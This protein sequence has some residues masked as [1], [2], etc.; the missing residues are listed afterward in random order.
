LFLLFVQAEDGIRDRNVTGV[1]TCALPICQRTIPNINRIGASRHF[2]N[3]RRV[4]IAVS[5]V[6]GKRV[7]IDGCR[8][9]DDFEVVAFIQ[10][11]LQIAQQE[12]DVQT[13]FVAS[14]MMMTEYWDRFGSCCISASKIP[15]VM[16]FSRVS[17]DT[18]D[19]NRTW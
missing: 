1:Q 7:R 9:N 6:L 12:V 5:K 13:A 16:T 18:S 2:D 8:G 17:D 14:S 3:R 19:V 11:T 15:S 4:A 10:Q